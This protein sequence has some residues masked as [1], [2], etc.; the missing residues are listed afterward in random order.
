MEPQFLGKLLNGCQGNPHHNGGGDDRLGNDHGGW[1]IED[2]QKAERAVSP[3]K[4]AHKK[5]HD[6]GGE[7]HTGIDQAD[8]NF[9]PGE[10]GKGNRYSNGYPEQEADEGGYPRNP[11]GKECDPHD[12]RV[13]CN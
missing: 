6:D 5:A 1:R 4:D 12:L 3:Q 2:P 11:K 10:S 13:K 7:R 9:F 8:S